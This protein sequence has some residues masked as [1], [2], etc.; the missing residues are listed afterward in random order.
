[1]HRLFAGFMV[2]PDSDLLHLTQ[3]HHC[4]P[5]VLYCFQPT[6]EPPPEEKEHL[7]VYTLAFLA[8]STRAVD[9][10]IVR[11]AV[12]KNH[13]ERVHQQKKEQR[14]TRV[15]LRRSREEMEK[16]RRLDEECKRRVE[17]VQ[18]RIAKARF[19]ASFHPESKRK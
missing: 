6:E 11:R 14:A 18:K 5:E 7:D 8:R 17:R 13:Q 12:E 9:A 4:P 10:T 19:L 16:Q 15:L 3:Q 1:M 2:W